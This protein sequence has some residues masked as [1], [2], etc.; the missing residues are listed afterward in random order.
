MKTELT[1]KALSGKARA[2]ALSPERRK[3]IAK[4][5][6]SIK[7]DKSILKATHGS[8]TTPLIIGNI[9][10]PC[11]I[12]SDKR[13]VLLQKNMAPA[14]GLSELSNSTGIT[15]LTNAKSLVNF[16]DTGLQEKIENP[17]KFR[18]PNGILANGYDASV[19]I[20]IC[21]AVLAANDKGNLAT[22]QK[23]VAK[24]CEVL[25]RSV[26]KVGIIALVDEATGYQEDR[27]K[28]ALSKILEEF[29]AKEL[30]PWVK[31]F[32]IDYYKQLCRLR[33]IPYVNGATQLPQYFGH[34]TNN[35]V[36]KR[37][38][39]GVLAELKNITPKSE[40]RNKTARYFQSL[41]ANKGYN[42]LTEH[43]GSVVTLMKLSD[44][45]EEFEIN[46]NRIHPLFEDA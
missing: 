46:L 38:A 37:L 20:D 25:I 9:K 42:R 13:R 8:D 17:I 23:H 44:D 6:I 34:L 43:L 40:A 28:N 1:G 10:I 7:N 39:P 29:I 27:E 19:L 35:I 11:Y 15:R 33:G 26:A 16:I 4:N 12:L 45:Y 22:N 32:S 5:A 24:Q 31:T 18:T 21:N 41:T 14:I 36:Y 30:K 3:E 2:A